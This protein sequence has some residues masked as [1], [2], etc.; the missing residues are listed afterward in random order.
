M[1]IILIAVLLHLIVH[2]AIVT[3]A[4]ITVSCK[5]TM[6]LEEHGLEIADYIEV[7]HGLYEIVK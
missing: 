6:K 1:S 5:L 4:M 2:R 7:A 3:P